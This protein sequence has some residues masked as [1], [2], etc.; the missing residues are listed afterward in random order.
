M[1]TIAE[2]EAYRKVADALFTDDE[3]ADIVARV[4]NDPFCG[5]V[6][7]GAGGFRKMRVARRGMGKRGGARVI[8]I[9]RRDDMPI[10]LAAAYAKNAKANFT[11]HER[12]Q[13]A[14]VADE[15]FEGYRR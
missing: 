10:I 6:I 1:Q 14:K 4:P 15:L 13:L 5:A 9:F 12:N 3:P 2:T 11:K 7:P 8:Y